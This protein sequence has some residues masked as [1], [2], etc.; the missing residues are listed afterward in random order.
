MES[1]E[2]FLFGLQRVTENCY[3]V[4]A[5][6]YA[7]RQRNYLY[8]MYYQSVTQMIA[9]GGFFYKIFTK[10]GRK[11]LAIFKRSSIMGN[12]S[13][14]LHIAPISLVGCRQDE[15]DIMQEARRCGLPLKV[16]RAD[17]DRYKIPVRLCEPIKG[18]IEY[19]YHAQEI[20]AMEGGKFH[21]Y[22]RAVRKVQKQ[23]GYRHVYGVNPDITPLIEAWDKH[24]KA[25]GAAGAQA[26]L[27]RRITALKAPQVHVHSVYTHGRLECFSVIEQ[28]SPKHWVLVMGVRNYN[29]PLNDVNK[30]IHFLDC[31]IAVQG[32]TQAVY[33]NLGAAVGRS[34]LEFEKEN[35]KPCA[36]Q[37]IYRV[38]PINRLDIQKIKS[39]LA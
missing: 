6:F 4:F 30:I 38:A 27:W 25:K 23:D 7:E 5:P 11:T 33:A 28:V 12:Y 16:C 13:V 3:A 22:R 24:N 2:S 20:A 26:H 36:H 39:L 37:Q 1:I 18:N 14:M 17:I 8:P 31:K 32:A 9:A 10:Q 35:L 21:G 19:I 29:S 15:L 34:G